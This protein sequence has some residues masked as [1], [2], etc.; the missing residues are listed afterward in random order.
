MK[1]LIVDDERISV[2]GLVQSADWKSYGFDEC[3]VAYDIEQAKR[4][5]DAE[6]V[7]LMLTDIEMNNGTGIDL[8]RWVNEKNL[9]LL[10]AVVS[11]H[12][13]FS[14]AKEAI[15]CGVTEYLV[16]PVS[17]QEMHD[18]LVKISE[19]LEQLEHRNRIARYAA[20]NRE[21]FWRDIINERIPANRET[22]IET[23]DKRGLSFSY[24][25]YLCIAYISVEEWKE[26]GLKADGKTGGKRLK[27]IL[28]EVFLSYEIDGF[29]LELSKDRYIYVAVGVK[30][31]RTAFYNAAEECV[32]VLSDNKVVD[33]IFYIGDCVSLEEISGEVKKLT[34]YSESTISFMNR[35]YYANHFSSQ[36]TTFPDARKWQQKLQEKKTDSVL[37]T[38]LFE[39]NQRSVDGKCPRSFVVALQHD[40]LQVLYAIL[41]ENDIQAHRFIAK[42]EALFLKTVRS[43]EELIVWY[44]ESIKTVMGIV[45]EVQCTDN[46]CRQIIA[47]INANLNSPLSRDEIAEHV[48][49]SSDYVTKLFKRETGTSLFEYIIQ[50]RIDQ[51][52]IYLCQ[53]DMPISEICEKTGFSSLSHFSATFKKYVGVRP[54]DYRRQ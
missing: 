52:K 48:Y 6:P 26:N 1:V 13:D 8:L 46:I 29:P 40:L 23:A 39:I 36:T 43:R 34:E 35:V 17:K 5:L 51:A 19:K 53:T 30:N 10:S 24:S 47:Y 7:Q 42:N 4:L 9:N 44:T 50:R 2:E 31:K 54:R 16:K 14:Y 33:S 25:D 11:C 41:R 45:D 18:F 22:I 49:L 15:S 32:K 20:E 38:I 21:Q 37:A 28:T 27:D 12:D 3:L